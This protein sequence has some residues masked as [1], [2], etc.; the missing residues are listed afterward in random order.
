MRSFLSG[1]SEKAS[2]SLPAEQ[3]VNVPVKASDTWSHD[4]HA[5]VAVAFAGAVVV[6]VGG[7]VELAAVVVSVRNHT[8]GTMISTFLVL[9]FVFVR[10]RNGE[11]D[12][13]P[14]QRHF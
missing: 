5:L 6:E 14:L 4:S 3:N 10:I 1:E 9:V 8:P 11:Q 2:W 7:G 13:R 12:C